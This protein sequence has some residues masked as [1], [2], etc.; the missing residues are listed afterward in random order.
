MQGKIAAEANQATVLCAKIPREPVS[1]MLMPELQPLPEWRH[2]SSLLAERQSVHSEGRGMGVSLLSF[3][4]IWSGVFLKGCQPA[5]VSA[6]GPG[7]FEVLLEMVT[8]KGPACHPLARPHS[9]K[10]QK[11]KHME[12]KNEKIAS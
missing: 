9:C 5:S 2:F 11:R 4:S 3:L 6:P 1:A 10:G 12:Q 8:G 7:I